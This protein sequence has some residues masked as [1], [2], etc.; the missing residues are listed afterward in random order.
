MKKSDNERF[1]GSVDKTGSCWVWIASKNNK[2]YGNFSVSGKAVFAHRYSYAL[3]NGQI[4]ES[5]HVLHK[6]DNPPC[7]NPEHLFL[8]SPADNM[9]D[10][11]AKGRHVPTPGE[12]NGNAVLTAGLVAE[13]RS[14]YN[15]GEYSQ[16]TLAAIFKISQPHVSALVN[17]KRWSQVGAQHV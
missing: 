3:V 5:K 17:N 11:D 12:S 15:T 9:A 2:G 14:L 1:W 10:R 8:G 6:C 13:I 7:V 16:R 4:P